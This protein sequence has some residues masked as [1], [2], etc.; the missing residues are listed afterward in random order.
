LGSSLIFVMSRKA[1]IIGS[2]LV[3]GLAV[4]AVFALL[5]S[6]QEFFTHAFWVTHFTQFGYFAPLLYILS[7]A[8]FSLCGL[9]GELLA[10]AGGTLFGL[11]SALWATVGVTLGAMVSFGLTRSLLHT[12]AQ[13]QFGR[14]K[15]L[16]QLESAVATSPLQLVM[17]ARIIPVAPL[18]LLNILFGL[19]TIPWQPYFWGTCLGIFPSRLIYAWLGASGQQAL[20]GGD[21]WPLWLAC[22]GLVSL[23]MTPFLLRQKR[24]SG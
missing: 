4:V 7:C 17:T 1:L 12:R 2:L 13:R 9:P 19:T 8:C 10:I 24:R 15:L 22:I 14:H 21:R 18:S 16:R 11:W 20:R 6:T 5:I 3:F 23:F